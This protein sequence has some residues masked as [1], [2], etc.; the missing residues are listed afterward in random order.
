MTKN[1]QLGQLRA[2]L[3]ALGSALAT[4]GFSDRNQW[5]PIVGIILA[6]WSLTW[7]LLHHK[8]PATP[9]TL[10]WSLVRKFA[11]ALGAAAVTYGWCHPDKVDSIMKILPLLG[12]ILAGWF[13]WI[14]NA[15]EEGDDGG[16]YDGPNGLA[17]L[18]AIGFLFFFLLPSC[19][20]NAPVPFKLKT[21]YG[22]LSQDAKGGLAA[23]SKVLDLTRDAD[24]TFTVIPKAKTITIRPE[25]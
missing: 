8:D 21:P 12:P 15:P 2:V 23:R 16:P 18:I 17:S 6:G 20:P 25:K 4:W 19:N 10:S 22:V 14:S 24:G 1:Q 5:A 9:G 13:S 11:N 3:L 7:G